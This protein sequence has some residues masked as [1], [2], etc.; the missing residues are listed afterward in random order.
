MNPMISV[1]VCTYNRE[2]LLARCL[3]SLA[4]QTL[5]RALYEVVVVENNCTD[6]TRALLER[7][8]AGQAN[9]QWTSETNQGLSWS[10]NRGATV[11]RGAWLAYIDDDA[12]APPE[13]LRGIHDV[14]RDHAPDMIGGPILP[15]YLDR[16]P[17]W[18][19]DEYEIRKYQDASGFSRTCG[20]KGSN[21]VLRKDLLAKLGD[22]DVELGMKGTTSAYGEDRAL[23]VKYR[24][25]TPKAEQRVYYAAHCPILHLVPR[26]KMRLGYIMRRQ[27]EGGRI[28]ISLKGK[29][30][31]GREGLRMLARLPLEYLYDVRKIDRGRP[32][33]SYFAVEFLRRSALYAGKLVECV[34]MTAGFALRRLSGR[35][36]RRRD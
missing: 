13:Y 21:Y 12:L 16:K 20:V 25:T 28:S 17:S 32:E 27:Y 9:L 19:L 26:H 14:I 35:A 4:E 18:F 24:A 2:T 22:F 31:S 10:R 29:V 1:I 7:R 11:A 8:A 3:D 15:Y 6:G 34:R 30:R 5:D 33:R 23:L 36:P